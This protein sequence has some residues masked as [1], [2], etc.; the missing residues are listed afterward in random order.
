MLIL[1]SHNVLG[2]L[3]SRHL[4]NSPKQNISKVEAVAAKNFNLLITFPHEHKLLVKQ[5]RQ[6]IEGK[7]VGEF[8]I[9]YRIQKWLQK[10]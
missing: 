8:K 5:E 9:E 6:N 7:A 3:S 10:F 1:N 4:C 2:Y